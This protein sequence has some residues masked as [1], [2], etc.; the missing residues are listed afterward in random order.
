MPDN[1]TLSM[2]AARESGGIN[3]AD[4]R[5]EVDP[6]PSQLAIIDKLPKLYKI[7][8][9]WAKNRLERKFRRGFYTAAQQTCAVG[10][11]FVLLAPSASLCIDFA[12]KLLA[13][14]NAS[15]ALIEPFLDYM[16]DMLDRN[17]AR[18]EACG[19]EMLFS[20]KVAEYIAQSS[21]KA[22]FICSP[23]NP[24]G[25]QISKEQ[26]T[27]LANACKTHGKIILLDT[28]YRFY[29][30][31]PYDQ[32][33][34]LLNSGVSFMVVEDTGKAFPLN[35]MKV[36][37]LACSKDLYKD[38][39]KIYSE[40]LLRASPIHILFAEEFLQDL[41]K[42]GAT[43]T[44]W[45]ATDTNRALL[46]NIIHGSPLKVAT[47]LSTT[48]LEWLRIDDPAIGAEKMAADLKTLGLHVLP[49]KKFF[50]SGRKNGD[51]YLRISLA[52][53]PDYFRKGMDILHQYLSGPQAP[54]L[55][56]P[57]KG[58]TSAPFGMGGK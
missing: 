58:G 7:S 53:N 38:L 18:F 33:Q 42:S 4:G 6:T 35:E 32:Y 5:Y 40:I 12:T 34:V 37:L 47:P 17:K 36:G 41:I 25:S 16:R 10:H 22:V 11:S 49:G 3:L 57:P 39:L 23:N 14:R 1:L 43:N 46:R 30:R 13:E 29:D 20:D 51:R 9:T 24:T 48:S 52:R 56:Q 8:R 50:W 28:T 44:I 45:K 19:E 31:Q 21:A 2:I 15:I 27:I 54:A 26:L 55:L